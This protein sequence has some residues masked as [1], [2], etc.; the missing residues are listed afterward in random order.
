MVAS[1]RQKGGG[2]LYGRRRVREGLTKK[3]GGR[4]DED[5]E[6]QAERGVEL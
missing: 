2:E 5:K 4:R 3:G 6:E 1:E